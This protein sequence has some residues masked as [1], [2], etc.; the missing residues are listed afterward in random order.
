MGY[1]TLN[2]GTSQ[3]LL[4][5]LTGQRV[6]VLTGAIPKSSSVNA[7]LDD[8]TNVPGAVNGLAALIDAGVLSVSYNGVVLTSADVLS[9]RTVETTNFSG[10]PVFTDATRPVAT[11]VPIG[12]TFYNSDDSAL[13][14]SDGTQWIDLALAAPT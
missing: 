2:K 10:Y 4:T 3:L 9:L 7:P 13:N 6:C 8:Y 14:L 11:S 1:R 5:N 12:Y